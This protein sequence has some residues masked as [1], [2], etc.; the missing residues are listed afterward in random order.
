MFSK[1]PEEYPLPPQ[2]IELTGL[3][4]DGLVRA[5]ERIVARQ[6]QADEI[7][8]VMGAYG[9]CQLR[10]HH[11]RGEFCINC[12]ATTADKWYAVKRAADACG[13]PEENIITF[14]DEYN[15]LAMLDAADYAYCPSDG[16]IAHLYETVCECGAGAVADVIYKKI[17]GILEKMG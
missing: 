4:V 9:D 15:D 7:M 1:L 16:R 3:T 12:N 10:M 6:T 14:G 11:A 13:V 8:E 17:P 5:L 2:P